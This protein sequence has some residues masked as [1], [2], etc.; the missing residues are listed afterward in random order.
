MTIF[1]MC[2]VALKRLQNERSLQL[3][4]ESWKWC[5]A[6]VYYLE[7]NIFVA[8]FLFIQQ[9]YDQT[10]HLVLW[11]MGVVNIKWADK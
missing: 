11:E 6:I 9:T 8:I 7:Q 3:R 10:F 1:R 5:T 2:G 4:S